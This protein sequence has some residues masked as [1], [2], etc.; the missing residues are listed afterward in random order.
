MVHQP[1]PLARAARS[2]SVLIRI[3]AG[4]DDHIGQRQVADAQGD[5]LA[6]QVLRTKAPGLNIR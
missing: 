3:R 4:I 2:N 1:A 5:Q 6:P